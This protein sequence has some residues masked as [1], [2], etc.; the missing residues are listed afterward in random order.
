VKMFYILYGHYVAQVD[1]GVITSRLGDKFTVQGY[2]VV[3]YDDDVVGTL[4][5]GVFANRFGKRMA[6]VKGSL[7]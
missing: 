1:N 3:N 4:I 7:A 6:I 5:D 2:A